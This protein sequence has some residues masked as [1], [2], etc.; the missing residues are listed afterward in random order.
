MIGDRVAILGFLL[1]IAISLHLHLLPLCIQ[2]CT[3]SDPILAIGGGF[4]CVSTMPTLTSDIERADL[5]KKW[6]PSGSLSSADFFCTLHFSQSPQCSRTLYSAWDLWDLWD[7][8]LVSYSKI[9]DA[10]KH[11]TFFLRNFQ[12][13]GLPFL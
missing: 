13:L 1:H 9:L 7:L 8:M 3:P 5:F 10:T 12:S 2:V 6:M 11:S 4:N